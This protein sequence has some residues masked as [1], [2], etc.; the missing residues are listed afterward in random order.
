MATML[1]FLGCVAFVGVTV[2]CFF[3]GVEEE[4]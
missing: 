4:E 3:G 2:M 1:V